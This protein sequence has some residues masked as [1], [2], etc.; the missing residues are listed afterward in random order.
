MSGEGI[1]ATIE[2]NQGVPE[3]APTSQQNCKGAL[4]VYNEQFHLVNS[5]TDMSLCGFSYRITASSG[6]IF[7]GVTDLRGFTERIATQHPAT[8]KI[9]VFD[10]E[11]TKEIGDVDG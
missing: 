1:S 11:S 2:K 10:M 7:E 6:E 9:E 8:L 3:L 4:C 5:E